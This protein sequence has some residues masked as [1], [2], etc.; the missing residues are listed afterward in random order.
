MDDLL[1]EDWQ[2]PSKA[3]T[4][5]SYTP[6]YSTL[7]PNPQPPRSGT[8][9]PQI[10]ASRPSSAVHN[11]AP[12]SASN[13]D[14]FGSIL[15][16]KSQ[17]AASNISIQER[18][19][20]IEKEKRRRAEQHSQLWD[21]LGSGRGTP[22]EGSRVSPIVPA[23]EQKGDEEEEDMLKAFGRD[24][25]VDRRSWYPPPS[26]GGSRKGTPGL[27]DGGLGSGG[28]GNAGLGNGG[29]DEDDDP[30][31][32]GAAPKLGNGRA[33]LAS[34]T[35]HV[36]DDDDD[37]LGNL[38][39]PVVKEAARHVTSKT[40]AEPEDD[41]GYI[42]L[43]VAHHGP[44]DQALA[45]LIE[46]GFP[47]AT[48]KIA[49][50]GNGGDVQ[51]AV[52]WLLQQAHEE[53]KQKARAMTEATH[54]R[55]RSPV[56]GSRSPPRGQ[57]S[58]QDGMPAWMRQ[59]SRSAS[60]TR[61]QE[62]RSPANGDKDAAAVAQDLGS[63]LFKGANS[64][65][66]ASQ[67]QMAKTMTEFQ[68]DGRDSS[69]PRWMHDGSGESSRASS[70]KR[71]E[72]RATPRVAAVRRTVVDVTDEAAMLDA[73]R[74]SRTLPP[75][76]AARSAVAPG[77]AVASPARGRSPT[78]MLPSRPSSQP[79]FTQQERPPQEQ[80]KRP[81]TKL[82]RQQVEEEAAQGYISASRRRRPTPKQP[83]PQ[84]DAEV[85]LF[86]SAPRPLKS[87]PQPQTQPEVDLFS[88]APPP[89]K[90]TPLAQRP[91][92]TAPRTRTVELP[93]AARHSHVLSKTSPQPQRTIP[94]LSPSALA[95]STRHRKLGGEAFKR[96]DYASA[97]DAYTLA[98]APLPATHPVAVIVLC[99][100]AL[101]ALK[102]GDAKTSV[103]D[104]ERAL[105]IIG[106]GRGVEEAIEL[107]DGEGRK[108]MSE[109]YGKALMR[110]AEALEHLEKWAE[111]AAVWRLAVEAGVGGA[112]SVR[113]RERCEKA[114]AGPTPTAKSAVGTAAAPVARKAGPGAKGRGIGTKRAPPAVSAAAAE[115]VG[116]LRA[117][118]AAAEKQDD[119]KFALADQVDAR[120]TAWKSGKADNLRALLQSLDTVLWEGAGW[121]KV[122]MADLVVVGR[123]R[124]VYQRAIG[125]VHPDKIPQDATTEQR[126]ISAAVFSTLNEAWDR[127][128]RENNL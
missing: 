53:S 32:L 48:A 29:L 3:A 25:V 2:A 59:E 124:G 123:V 111:G 58:E 64:L 5:P 87:T 118:N 38:S 97:H 115:A 47:A 102:T 6:S 128:K 55:K 79:K 39:R 11:G 49:L 9:S 20:Q 121:K 37:I 7:L 109:F 116:A 94:P 76:S 113:G 35:Q 13:N 23:V 10:Q 52:G 78:E 62:S 100:R 74:E 4:K 82:S 106:S 117:A 60:A 126:M 110:K 17:K 42:D 33:A 108:Q 65:W 85:D 98:L 105:G 54:S 8:V 90:S 114:A 71:P 28:L 119:E 91:A 26:L 67:K 122:G 31:G 66:K 80:D 99:N 89:S 63:K 96:G 40:A 16:L 69:Q 19:G 21:T 84:P 18:Q 92:T 24:V 120:L 1:G 75:K 101:T 44:E 77:L 34:A 83:E 57:R 41:V 12:K 15:S 125:R 103:S 112:V 72:E 30:F 61:R 86:S 56:A 43:A 46:M 50:A 107:G 104:A 22:V 51:G 45:E 14:A 27:G 70:Q 81:A 93:P 127:F 68:A 73:P 88:S 95:T 36:E